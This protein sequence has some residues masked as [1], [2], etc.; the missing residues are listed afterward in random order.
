MVQD[1]KTMYGHL[2]H[3]SDTTDF[4]LNSYNTRWVFIKK[5]IK[6]AIALHIVVVLGIGS[7]IYYYADHNPA[8][9]PL[10]V[11]RKYIDRYD[12]KPVTVIPF[13][14]IPDD[15]KKMVVSIEDYKFYTH[16]G[17]DLEAVKRAIVINHKVGY[18]MYGASTITQQLAR[19]L[20][21]LPYKSIIRKYIELIIALEMEMILDKDRIL[22]LYC[23]YCEMGKG[24]FG[25]KNASYYYFGKDIYHLNT[26]EKSR[27]LA[28][29]ANPILFSPYNFKNSKLIT[30]RYY[31][32]KFRYYT[33][34]KYKAMVQYAYH[35]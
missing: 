33:Y 28:I 3:W 30:N 23:N 17:V 32:L 31:I 8:I 15:I 13:K 35:N 21:L 7:L 6:V 22:E 9:T 27:M 2:K 26:D 19:T 14:H 25:F 1:L 34:N 10:M 20:F 12:V 16:N 24:V 29:L 18:R 11:Y 5:I 4:Y